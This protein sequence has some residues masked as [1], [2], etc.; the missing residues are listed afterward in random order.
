MAATYQFYKILHCVQ[1]D[2]R[3]YVMGNAVKN[4]LRGTYTQDKYGGDL[5]I[6]EDSSLSLRMTKGNF[7]FN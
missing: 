3:E 2:K 6:V 5:S 1:N 4:L 7:S